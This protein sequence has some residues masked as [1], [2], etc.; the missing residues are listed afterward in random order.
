MLGRSNGTNFAEGGAFN[1]YDLSYS[2]VYIFFS[3]C[4]TSGN[5]SCLP[6]SVPLQ[7]GG[8]SATALSVA[9]DR[10][11]VDLAGTYGTHSVSVYQKNEKHRRLQHRIVP[12][13]VCL[14]ILFRALPL[15]MRGPLTSCYF[16]FLYIF[17]SQH[18]ICLVCDSPRAGFGDEIMRE[19]ST[20]TCTIVW[21]NL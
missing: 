13:V 6:V 14:L 3:V 10:V 19:S 1:D 18:D 20:R 12:S 16:S 9:V 4:N 5:Y 8:C 15:L 21:T 2:R 11:V 7:T 17:S